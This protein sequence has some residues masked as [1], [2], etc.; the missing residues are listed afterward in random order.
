MIPRSGD[1]VVFVTEAGKP[2]DALVLH[3]D[4]DKKW[5]VLVHVNNADTQIERRVPR[6]EQH[7]A[8]YWCWPQEYAPP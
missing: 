8:F 4:I 5:V 7:Q 2:K 1:H 6:L 3:Y